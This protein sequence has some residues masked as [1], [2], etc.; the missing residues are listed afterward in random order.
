MDSSFS[1]VRDELKKS[2]EKIE[3]VMN[4]LSVTLGYPKLIISS[5]QINVR[6]DVNQRISNIINN[7]SVID[8]DI[9]KVWMAGD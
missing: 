3:T 9:D 5:E 7:L 4:T 6:N 8:N 2:L 1:I